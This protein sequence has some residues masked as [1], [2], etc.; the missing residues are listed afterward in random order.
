MVC[1]FIYIVKDRKKTL[2]S[3]PDLDMTLV[4]KKHILSYLSYDNRLL[5]LYKGPDKN[6]KLC[7]PE[8]IESIDEHAFDDF[9]VYDISN[10]KISFKENVS[11]SVLPSTIK[12]M[13]ID[14][15]PRGTTLIFADARLKSILRHN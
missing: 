4:N 15:I 7:V 3:I 14:T 10:G 2:A 11:V 6:R 12:K 5:R 1:H 8:G 13:D 9:G